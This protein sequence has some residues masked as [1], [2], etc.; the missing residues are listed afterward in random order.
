MIIYGLNG[1]AKIEYDLCGDFAAPSPEW[2]HLTRELLNF[3][4]FVVT[5]G[6]L[7]IADSA[8]EYCIK[9]GEYLL[10]APNPHEHGFQK[11][12][13]S[14]YWVHFNYNNGLNNCQLFPSEEAASSGLEETGCPKNMLLL[15]Q[16]GVLKNPERVASMIETLS[17]TDLRCHNALYNDHLTAALLCEIAMQMRRPD[18]DPS[19][20]H[21]KQLYDDICSYIHWH[22]CG[23]L[24]VP[25]I[26]VHFGYNAKYLSTFFREYSGDTLKHRIMEDKMS[27]AK[28]QLAETTFS[29]QQVAFNVGF[30]DAHNFSN[31]FRKK[32]G[33]S[34]R[35]YREQLQENLKLS[36]VK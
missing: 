9:K 20:L 12:E 24:S 19:A 26:A 8:N 10:M 2:I 23:N 18:A 15:P 17:E 1:D 32:Y 14:F 34:P 35:Q 25:A 13:C 27:H 22:A 11:C 29:I 36:H 16:K 31:A 5:K 4:L 33:F 30:Q 21:K 3:E 7:L 28:I 6:Q